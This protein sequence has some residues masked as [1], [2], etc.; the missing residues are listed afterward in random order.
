MH[1]SFAQVQHKQET[2][3]RTPVKRI[4]AS[5]LITATALFAIVG[6]AIPYAQG[7]D[8]DKYSLISPD[9]I[10]FSDF[11]GYEDWSLVSSGR[12]EEVLKV[13]VANPTMIKAY[14]AGNPGNGELFPEGSMIVKLQW[15]PKKSTE[16][17]LLPSM[18]PM[19]LSRLS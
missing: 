3:T 8:K 17:R 19:S 10:A 16:A 9:G 11:G 5:T 7:Q 4:A 15:K 6:G 1:E 2:E 12:T 14:K 13:I 18:C